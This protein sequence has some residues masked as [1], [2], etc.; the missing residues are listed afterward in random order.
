MEI[1]NLF[2]LFNTTQVFVDPTICIISCIQ[3]L[4]YQKAIEYYP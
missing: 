1:M 2:S 3:N 4:Q